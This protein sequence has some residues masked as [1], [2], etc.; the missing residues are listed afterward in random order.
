[1]SND[2]MREALEAAISAMRG[3][4]GGWRCESAIKKCEEALAAQPATAPD[5]SHSFKNFHRSLCDRFGYCHDDKDWRRDLISLEEHIAKQAKPATV[6]EGCLV[7][8][9]GSAYDAPEAKRAYTYADQPGN[10]AASKL[11]RALVAARRETSPDGTDLGLGLLKALQEEGFGVFDLGAEYAAPKPEQQEA[12]TVTPEQWAVLEEAQRHIAEVRNRRD[13]RAARLGIE[14]QEAP[15][16]RECRHCGFLCRPNPAE[17]RKWYPLEQA[18]HPVIPE[19][20]TEQQEA[21]ELTDEWRKLAQDISDYQL[22]GD[23]DLK[24]IGERAR[25]LLA[26]DRARRK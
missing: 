12:P 22:E 11:G 7:G 13:E 6:P 4:Y 23:N 16:E 1:M 20:S 21:P 5:D 14:Q 24:C 9:R 26:A 15:A 25:H 19:S 17:S 8:I 10:V 2:M 3:L 18:N